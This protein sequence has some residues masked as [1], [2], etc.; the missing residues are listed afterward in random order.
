MPQIEY[1]AGAWIT[2]LTLVPAHPGQ[3]THDI[4]ST[5]SLRV[6][7]QGHGRWEGVVRWKVRKGAAAAGM[8]AMLTGLDVVSNFI[9]LPIHRPTISAATT[10]AAE[11]DGVYTLAADPG[12]AILGAYVR[13][14]NRLF[15]VQGWDAARLRMTLWPDF[16][17]VRGDPISPALSVRARGAG[18]VPDMPRTPH[19]SGPWVLSWVEAI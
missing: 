9:E 16:P 7:E 2:E 17:L 1:Y 6:F 12:D 5:G 8:E 13:S 10:V 14:H 4:P 15:S 18:G 19:W 11:A 3:I